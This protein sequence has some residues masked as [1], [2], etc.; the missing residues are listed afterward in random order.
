MRVP[1][2]AGTRRSH[3]YNGRAGVL[4]GQ[5]LELAGFVTSHSSLTLAEVATSPISHRETNSHRVPPSRRPRRA[6]AAAAAAAAAS[7]RS[8]PPF[9][10]PDAIS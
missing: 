6:A 3:G 8:A 5:A 10:S 1:L 7:L 4:T 9:S 2:G